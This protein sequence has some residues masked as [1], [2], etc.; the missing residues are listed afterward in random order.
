MARESN[1]N[2]CAKQASWQCKRRSCAAPAHQKRRRCN[3]NKQVSSAKLQRAGT[4]YAIIKA[5]FFVLYSNMHA[6]SVLSF[7]STQPCC[8]GHPCLCCQQQPPFAHRHQQGSQEPGDNR[9]SDC[10]S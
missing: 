2:F 9:E 5:D 3:D 4:C 6:P 7:S 1:K 8:Q 10:T